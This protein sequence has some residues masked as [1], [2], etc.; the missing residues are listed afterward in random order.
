[1]T[2]LLF[3]LLA[4]AAPATAQ[5]ALR[6]VSQIPLLAV[7]DGVHEDLDSLIQIYWQAHFNTNAE[8]AF[9][10]EQLR[11][12]R[13]DLDGDGRAELVLMVDAIGWNA[14]QG[15]P[16]VVAQWIN[17]R[18]VA[19]GWG[20]GDEDTVFVTDEIKDGWRSI[21]TGTQLLRW[22]GTEYSFSDKR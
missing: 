20:W 6:P 8:Y 14:D 7:A 13:V 17:K 15:S 9:G 10:R 4:L 12:G 1:M 11:V 19:I 3:V 18:W 21:D 22:A 5:E 2:A 16:F